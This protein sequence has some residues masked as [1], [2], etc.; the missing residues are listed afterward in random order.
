MYVIIYDR[1]DERNL[2]ERFKGSKDDLRKE[3]ET[4]KGCGYTN[5]TVE[6]TRGRRVDI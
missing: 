3:I 1:G 2:C 5:I 4:L 6:T